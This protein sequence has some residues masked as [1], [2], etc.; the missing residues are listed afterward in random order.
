[1][2]SD[3]DVSHHQVSFQIVTT[4]VRPTTNKKLLVILLAALSITLL[5][6]L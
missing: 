3:E 5:V 1:M 4:P 6:A 2:V